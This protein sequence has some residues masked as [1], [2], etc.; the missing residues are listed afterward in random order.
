MRR[1]AL[2][3]LVLAGLSPFSPAF[4]QTG[5]TA[6]FGSLQTVLFNQ[7]SRVTFGQLQAGNTTV[8]HEE[9]SSFAVQQL[10]IFLQ[11][12]IGEHFSAFVDLEYQLNYSSDKKWGSLSL[13]EAWLN[14]APIDEINLKV[15]MLYPAF[16]NL[17][18]IKN[19]LALLP[20][21]FR[22]GIYER[23]LSEVYMAEDYLPEH[24]F[25]QLSGL[26]PHGDIFWDY[27]LYV[28][29]AEGSYISRRGSDGNPDNDLNQN[30][31]FLT[32]VD[33]TEF[34]MKLFGGRLGI[35]ARNENFKAGFSLT[36]DYDNF[37]DTTRFPRIYNGI[38][39][40]LVGDAPRFR[41]GADLSGS[42][43][44]VRFESEFIR[45]LYDYHAADRLDIELDHLFYYTMLGYQF[46]DRLLVYGLYEAGQDIFDQTSEHSSFSGG[47]AFQ[48]N[49]DITAKAQYIV[50]KND[51]GHSS[52]EEE[53]MIRFV[54]LGFS[55]VL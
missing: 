52:H 10:D 26:L 39:T 43:G 37:R 41:I 32:G 7:K 35:R 28:G 23:L 13:Q 8:L 34:N 47:A 50:Y 17:N 45:V 55:I 33:P 46:G 40:P 9:R 25:V 6:I 44:N 42:V 22:P 1:S 27:A 21:I 36:H 19:R 16:N 12:P 24:A 49:A 3:F 11:K 4:G 53:V 30:F 38:R 15:G 48:L 2:V 29:N 51:Y 18:E 31:E 20:Y 5:E 14:Y 54:F